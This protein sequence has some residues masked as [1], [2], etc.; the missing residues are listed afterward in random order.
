MMF[1]YEF[2]WTKMLWFFYLSFICDLIIFC[3]GFPCE[4]RVDRVRV[5]VRAYLII[6]IGRQIL[7]HFHF[8]FHHMFGVSPT[9]IGTEYLYSA[10]LDC[11][12]H[13]DSDGRD[14]AAAIE[15]PSGVA[16]SATA[17]STPR[18]YSPWPR[19]CWLIAQ[20]C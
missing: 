6:F 10:W 11:F 8:H 7:F 12:W 4:H 17:A 3:V 16:T 13:N 14:G 9:P 1:I 20:I 2:N 15:S 19:R 18:Y 5:E